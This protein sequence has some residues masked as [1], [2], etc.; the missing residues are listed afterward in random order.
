MI[1]LYS[2]DTNVK[3]LASGTRHNR[4][5]VRE[6]REMQLARDEKKAEFGKPKTKK[7]YDNRQRRFDHAMDA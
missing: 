2:E 1:N 6:A 7:P 5:Q 3:N 4:L